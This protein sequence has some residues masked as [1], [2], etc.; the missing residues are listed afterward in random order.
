M[1]LHDGKPSVW[2][3][4]FVCGAL[5]FLYAAVLWKLGLDWWFD[6][7][8]SHGL[9]VPVLIAFIVWQRYD[10]LKNVSSEGRSWLGWVFISTAV[11]LLL[12]GTLASILYAQRLSLLFMI[13]GVIIRLY[14]TAMI[15]QLSMPLFLFFLA[16][17]IPQILFNKIAFPLQILASRIAGAC[18]NIVGIPASRLGNVIE[19]PF[20]V[21]GEMVSLEVVE[22]CSGIRSV[23]TL[24]ALALILGYFTREESESFT[25]G[26]SGGFISK[27]VQ[28]TALLMIMSVPAA[29]LTNAARVF[30]TGVLAHYFGE[31]SIEGLWHELA[32]TFVFLS[33]MAILLALNI[34]LK[35]VFRQEGV[36]S[37]GCAS[38][39]ERPLRI[40]EVPV[41]AP[42]SILL[43]ILLSGIL[44]NWL[45]YRGEVQ[46]ARLP[47]SEIPSRLGN[48][49]Q[50]NP[51]IRFD[52][53]SEKVLRAT[54][55]VMRDYYGPGKRLNIYVG[56]Y[57]TQ[58][59]GSTYHSPLNCLPGTGWEMT[60]PELIRIESPGGKQFSANLYL[61]TRGEHREYLIYWYQGRG[62]TFT[63]EY[64]EKLYTSLDSIVRQRTDGGM[65]R[66]MTPLGKDPHRSLAA[67]VDLSG[68]LADKIS[69]F[70]PD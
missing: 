50:R 49:E 14:G 19:I 31:G 38:A 32:G 46:V 62:R 24:I 43:V 25:P 40:A 61:V 63:S 60:E 44:V 64:T 29:L 16:I 57:A 41:K 20:R 58:R 28:R 68:N 6:E 11:I 39:V 34:L 37:E 56:Y 15:R 69:Q 5:L 70:L 9:L 30:V 2:L 7:N 17:P 36:D 53:E 67:A 52:A 35:W 59:G 33:A 8:Y 27:D 21:T 1:R 51:D 66:I 55:Y 47:L 12:V 65:V 45:Q 26:S 3:L 4:P 23:V 54:D 48:W 10:N 13:I 42:V 18:M 22:A